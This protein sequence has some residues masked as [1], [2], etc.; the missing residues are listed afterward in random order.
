MVRRTL[1]NHLPRQIDFSPSNHFS[2]F[3]IRRLDFF[4]TFFI[5]KKSKLLIIKNLYQN[6]MNVL[7]SIQL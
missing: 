2:A 1:K 4:I 3:F 7:L 6:N 5:K